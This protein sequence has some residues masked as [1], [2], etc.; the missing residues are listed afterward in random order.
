MISKIT[1][2]GVQFSKEGEHAALLTDRK[3]GYFLQGL[4]SRYGGWYIGSEHG[5]IKV[6]DQLRI[7]AGPTQRIVFKDLIEDVFTEGSLSVRYHA[8]YPALIVKN[9]TGFAVEL[10]FDVRHTYSQP[11]WNHKYSRLE[12]EGITYVHYE[13]EQRLPTKHG[14]LWIAIWG[15]LTIEHQDRWEKQEYLFDRG[16]GSFPDNRFCYTQAK[17]KGTSFFI[18]AH[19]DL[20]ELKNIARKVNQFPDM[21]YEKNG[22]NRGV[23]PSLME[24]ATHALLSFQDTNKGGLVAGLPWFFQRWL[25]DE[26]ISLGGLMRAGHLDEAAHYLHTWISYFSEHHKLPNMLPVT[27]STTSDGPAWLCFRLAS[28][29][30]IC[31]EHKTYAVVGGEK[32]FNNL[33]KSLEQLVL[34]CQESRDKRGLYHS[35]R[36]ESWMDAPVP[37]DDR[38][39]ALIEIQTLWAGTFSLLQQITLDKRYGVLE[40]ELHTL[41]LNNFYNGTLLADRAE[42]YTIRSNI[43]LAYYSYPKLLHYAEWKQCFITSIPRLWASWGGITTIDTLHTLFKEHSTGENKNSYH[44]GDSWFW[45][46]AYAAKSLFALDPHYFRAEIA[47]LVNNCITHHLFGPIMGYGPELRGAQD[48]VCLGSPAQTWS[49]GTLIELLS[50][51]GPHYAYLDLLKKQGIDVHFNDGSYG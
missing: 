48:P 7:N 16:R 43:F 40:L 24:C 46:N 37:G 10:F 5:P 33:L 17:I 22:P 1:I 26:M 2:T 23:Y 31:K 29:L 36:G 51:I 9:T 49:S 34:F 13:N 42:D 27:S 28:L 4:S 30:T 39:G 14:D 21:R 8:L 41:I 12:E 38:D 15:Q 18:A 35:K 11:E 44:R 45:I 47:A 32:A 50:D 25:R 3:G 20:E 6:I 19:E